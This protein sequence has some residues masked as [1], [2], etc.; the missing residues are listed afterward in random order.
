MRFPLDIWTLIFLEVDPETLHV[1]K[2]TCR[3]FC[4]V[5]T[6]ERFWKLVPLI[7]SYRSNEAAYYHRYADS[8]DDEIGRLETAIKALR[9]KQGK[10]RQLVRKKEGNIYNHPRLPQ[11][12]YLSGIIVDSSGKLICPGI[13]SYHYSELGYMDTFT[14]ERFW[15]LLPLIT[16][17]PVTYDI[18]DLSTSDVRFIIC[19]QSVC[20]IPVTYD[21]YMIP[22]DA[23][24]LL[25]TFDVKGR[26]DLCHIY[27]VQS[28]SRYFGGYEIRP[29]TYI[30][31]PSR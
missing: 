25:T 23:L 24:D 9:S 27:Q 6:S 30:N 10:I 28:G 11:I 12:H 5:L 19:P 29:E 4:Q 18:I 7:N 22:L 14:H 17:T 26:H 16:F 31:F 20:R 2:R 8:L 13:P 21:G 1:L 15:S 3:R